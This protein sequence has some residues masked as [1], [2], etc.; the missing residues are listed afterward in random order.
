MMMR[1]IVHR[2]SI[3]LAL[4]LGAA[5]LAWQ[6]FSGDATPEADADRPLPELRVTLGASRK[7]VT[8]AGMSAADQA[9]FDRSGN[10]LKPHLLVLTLPD[11]RRIE[12]TSRSTLV[13]LN[14]L[15]HDA[16]RDE[17]VTTLLV[18][19]PVTPGRFQEVVA[20]MLATIRSM[21]AEP[22]HDMIALTERGDIPG[23][24]AVSGSPRVPIN[25]KGVTFE[26]GTR[27]H[28]EVRADAERGW[29][30]LYT[31]NSNSDLWPSTIQFRERQQFYERRLARLVLSAQPLVPAAVQVEEM[32][33]V[34]SHHFGRSR[35]KGEGSDLN[36][37]LIA[38]A[39]FGDRYHLTML[40][41]IEFDSSLETVTRLRGEPTFVL[42]ELE[43]ITGD[44]SFAGR[45]EPVW[46]S[47]RRFDLAAWNKVVAAHGDF[48]AIGIDIDPTP[49][50]R[51][52]DY[53]RHWRAKTHQFSVLREA[54]ERAVKSAKPFLPAAAEIERMFPTVDKEGPFPS[55]NH[56]LDNFFFTGKESD[57]QKTF[58]TE[59]Y[60]GTRYQLIMRCDIELDKQDRTVTR[61]RG[62]PLFTLREFGPGTGVINRPTHVNWR[63]EHRFTLD[64]WNKVVAANGDF[65]AIGIDIDKSRVSNSDTERAWSY[66]DDQN[67]FRDRISLLDGA[68]ESEGN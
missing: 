37:L 49:V 11:S 55:T 56:F 24:E 68:E 33:P 38:E 58:V 15:E 28:C 39:W 8:T 17:I 35:P 57:F 52:A 7:L 18:R 9:V 36:D 54:R 60:F 63:R 19:Q 50:P 25:A 66:V 62:E 2:L 10:F 53:I 3:G 40:V 42:Q 4:G 47:E 30:V 13:R 6:S 12:L 64:D 61:L 41:P 29:F 32:F 14:G 34:T 45:L 44:D 65:S 5:G 43:E 16:S 48:S 31:I 51:A 20:D 67:R 46:R 27:V 21:G 22:H 1:V 23:G 59:A 26:D